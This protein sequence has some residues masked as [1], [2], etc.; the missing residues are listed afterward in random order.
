MI[1]TVDMPAVAPR[2]GA[3]GRAAARREAAGG[4]S[5]TAR[6]AVQGQPP[7]DAASAAGAAGRLRDQVSAQHDAIDFARALVQDGGLQTA[8]LTMLRAEVGQLQRE[9]HAWRGELAATRADVDRLRSELLRLAGWVRGPVVE[10]LA[11]RFAAIDAQIRRCAAGVAGRPDPSGRDTAQMR[12]GCGPDFG[13]PDPG[14][15]PA[16]PPPPGPGCFGR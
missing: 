2:R 10:R 5:V 11:V 7:D 4:A 12:A 13:T 1:R 9:I 3:N 8:G 6:G 16:G 14:A 15:G